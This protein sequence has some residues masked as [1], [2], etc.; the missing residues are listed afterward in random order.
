M[1]RIFLAS[2]ISVAAKSI[3]AEISKEYGN[4]VRRLLFITTASEPKEGDLSWQKDNRQGLAD[5]GF[6]ISDF[7]ITGKTGDEIQSAI[8][9]V[10]VIHFNGGN[11]FYLLKQL[12]LTNSIEM[13]KSAIEQGKIYTGSSA[14]SIIAAPNIFAARNL[15]SVKQTGELEDYLGFGLIDFLIFPHWGS[16][17]F[18]NSYLNQKLEIAYTGND[19]II[20]LRD[21]QYV[22]VIG[23]QYKIVGV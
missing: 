16:E 1:K 20:L 8:K 5:A 7:T 17:H 2:S 11:V 13:F 3:A 14:G 19:K 9:S 15:D 4:K 22:S 10:D 23:D 21:G 12:Q 6:V 18:K